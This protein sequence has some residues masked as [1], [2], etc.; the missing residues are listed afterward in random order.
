MKCFID[1]KYGHILFRPPIKGKS[2]FPKVKKDELI[3]VFNGPL[4]F[5]D[6]LIYGTCSCASCLAKAIKESACWEATQDIFT[7]Q[8]CFLFC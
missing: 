8:V 7:F 1:V 2:M 4:D 6:E 5:D 3:E